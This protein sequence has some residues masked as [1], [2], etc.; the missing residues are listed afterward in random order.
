MFCKTIMYFHSVL[1]VVVSVNF[2]V[3]L[4]TRNFRRQILSIIVIMIDVC[5]YLTF[6]SFFF[7]MSV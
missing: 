5:N 3:Q 6:E 7:G 4:R 1:P 2:N